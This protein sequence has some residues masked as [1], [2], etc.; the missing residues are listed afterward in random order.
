[1]TG[2][3]GSFR[4]QIDS[5]GRLNLP[6]KFRRPAGTMETYVITP[7]LNGCLNVFPEEEWNKVQEKL[8]SLVRNNPDNVY[9]LRTTLSRSFVV[10]ADNQGRITL[11][12]ALIKEAKLEKDV[13]V[14]GMLDRME[15][16]NPEIFADYLN[17]PDRSYEE[18]ARKID[19]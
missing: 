11:S 10:Q 15:I 13:L 1:M 12:A 18:V 19:I 17:K 9:Y 16:W 5:K 7:G 4:H 14:V 3:I 8:Q 6:A 2:F